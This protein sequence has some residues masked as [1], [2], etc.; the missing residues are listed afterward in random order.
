ML[1]LFLIRH[2]ETE[3]NR[4][5]IVQG[6]GINSELNEI[7][8]EQARRFFESYR[9]IPF[10]ALYAS[11][12]IRSYQTLQPFTQLGYKIEQ[13]SG[14]DEISW[15]DIEGQPATPEVR[16][17]FERITREWS[18]GNLH[19]AMTNG[20][21]PLDVWNRFLLFLTQIEQRYNNGG[22]ILICTHGRTLR[23]LLSGLLGYG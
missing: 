19:V 21:N 20:E 8:K 17:Q 2:G 7:G 3:F 4:L 16:S 13:H 22:N 1:K 10:K 23:I 5:N 14:L 15:G 18:Y 11:T 9:H 12:L 6:K